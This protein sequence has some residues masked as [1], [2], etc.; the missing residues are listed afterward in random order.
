[1]YGYIIQSS[2]ASWA[3]RCARRPPINAAGRLGGFARRGRARGNSRG[4][5]VG[6]APHV[7]ASLRF[8]SLPRLAGASRQRAPTLRSARTLLRYAH[9]APTVRPRCPPPPHAPPPSRPAARK[10]GGGERSE[11][12]SP[13]PPPLH[14]LWRVH[15][16]N[17]RSFHL[18]C[19]FHLYNVR[20]SHLYWLGFTFVITYLHM[21]IILFTFVMHNHMTGGATVGE[22]RAPFFALRGG[23]SNA[24]PPKAAVR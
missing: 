14:L 24:E 15:L 7:R 8:G 16:C 13:R 6:F 22:R 20:S 17:V 12:P 1:M 9:P 5:G 23:R 3:A 18:Y 19:D 11:P 4:R 2:G 10:L 21:S